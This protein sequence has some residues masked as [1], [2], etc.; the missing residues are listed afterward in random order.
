METED[1]IRFGSFHIKDYEMALKPTINLVKVEKTKTN[2]M[3]NIE[4]DDLLI[5]FG[6]FYVPDYGM[7]FK[8]TDDID[9]P[10]LGRIELG[11]LINFNKLLAFHPYININ[12]FDNYEKDM[13]IKIRRLLN[14]YYLDEDEF[15]KEVNGMLEDEKS[16]LSQF[17]S[18]NENF[19]TIHYNKKYEININSAKSSDHRIINSMNCSKEEKKSMINKNNEI[20]IKSVQFEIRRKT[21]RNAGYL[22]QP[23]YRNYYNFKSKEKELLKKFLDDKR[24]IYFK[25][26]D[27]IFSWCHNNKDHAALL[28]WNAA[29]V[30]QNII[31]V[32]VIENPIKYS[33]RIKELTNDLDTLNKK[34]GREN[35]Y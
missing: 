7:S 32:L 24:K 17:L 23:V 9:L 27:D 33:V 1:L 31:E 4:K 28:E 11:N 16:L 12:I 35:G 30:L 26:E 6:S 19:L 34:I 15:I 13:V 25:N 22:L 10:K 5:Q 29:F 14:K 8:P 18:Y 20:A 21:Y 3:L 2:T